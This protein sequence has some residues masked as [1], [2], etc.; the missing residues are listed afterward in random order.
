MR[1]VELLADVVQEGSLVITGG[2]DSGLLDTSSGHEVLRVR[3]IDAR[4]NMGEEGGGVGENCG[5]SLLLLN[6]TF[7]KRPSKLFFFSS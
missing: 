4:L 5:E 2:G 3:R 6:N 1:V 7:V